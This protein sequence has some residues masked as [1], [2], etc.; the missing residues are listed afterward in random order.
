MPRVK[1]RAVMSSYGMFDAPEKGVRKPV[2]IDRTAKPTKIGTE[3]IV[4][5]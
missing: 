2:D 1:E 5:P 4:S 3:Y